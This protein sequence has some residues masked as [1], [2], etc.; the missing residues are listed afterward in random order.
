MR[1]A[2][3]L[4]IGVHEVNLATATAFVMDSVI[5][6]KRGYVCVTGVHG[7]ME[8][9]RDP[10]FAGVLNE[11]MLVVPDGMPTVWIG[12][13][14]GFRKIG[15][16]FGPDFMLSVCAS[17]RS[18]GARHFLYGG[19]TGVAE[20][21]RHS[22]CT[23][24]SGVDIVGTYT[25]PFRPLNAEEFQQLVTLVRRLKPDIIWVGLSTPKQEQFMRESL[26][27][28]DTTLM[29][30]VGAAFDFLTGR[31]N[32]SPDWLK[33]CGMQWAHRLAQDPRRLWKRYMFNNPRFLCALALQAFKGKRGLDLSSRQNSLHS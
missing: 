11:A 20:T 21:L 28:L 15:R 2:D 33:K 16:V 5:S 26:P 23:R 1:R 13:T 30:G 32:D 18:H 24:V 14:Q 29:I 19:D 25:P 4:G 8:A 6:R 7:I 10:R 27:F 17:L 31:I 3:I 12:R 22:L 9:R